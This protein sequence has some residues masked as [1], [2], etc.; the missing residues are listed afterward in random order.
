M[1]LG[2]QN[3]PSTPGSHATLGQRQQNSSTFQATDNP[4]H[5]RGADRPFEDALHVMRPD[6]SK[7]SLLMD[8]I[9]TALSL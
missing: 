5:R 3:Y 8:Q 4:Q 9:E 7:D 6:K 2:P 1:F